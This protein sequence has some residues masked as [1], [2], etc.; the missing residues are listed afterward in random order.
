VFVA[1]R[2]RDVIME[3]M[4]SRIQR[5]DI[6]AE[7]KEAIEVSCTLDPV[8]LRIYFELSASSDSWYH[9]TGHVGHCAGSSEE[10]WYDCNAQSSDAACILC[11]RSLIGQTKLSS[12]RSW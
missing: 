3:N 1:G 4:R 7:K 6:E 8:S 10:D 9:P 11:M 5:G 12:S 2:N